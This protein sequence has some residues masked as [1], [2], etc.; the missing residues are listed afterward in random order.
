MQHQ[1]HLQQSA[2]WRRYYTTHNTHIT[3]NKPR[4]K[5]RIIADAI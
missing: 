1:L 2:L 5:L 3:S 4:K